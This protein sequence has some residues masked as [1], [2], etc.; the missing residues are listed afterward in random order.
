MTW[1]ETIEHS[2]TFRF[3]F[4]PADETGFVLLKDVAN[5]PGIGTYSTSILFPDVEATNGT[6]Q[7][8]QIIHSGPVPQ[9][10]P[11]GTVH[12]SCADVNLVT[13][14]LSVADLD[15]VEGQSDVVH[16]VTIESSVA[17]TSQE[18]SVDYSGV[19]GTATEGSDF[20][21]TAATATMGAGE[22]TVQVE[23]DILGDKLDEDNE[24]FTFELGDSVDAS[25]PDS[26]A[27]ILIR[28]NDHR[29]TISLALSKH[30]IVSGK[31][32]VPDGPMKCARNVQVKIQRKTAS[33]WSTLTT[34]ST[35]LSGAYRKQIA[36]RPGTYRGVV[37]QITRSFGGAPHLC[38]ARTSASAGHR[39][40]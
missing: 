32:S 37:S 13:P 28:D 31:V 5:A 9:D 22:T 8:Q 15:F 25:I 7:M 6:L 11:A 17:L 14:E 16:Q 36:D 30:L 4:S 18:V 29:R 2:G 34:D 19:P 23:V 26:D 3:Q 12:Y 38:L 35:D 20:D 1:E 39:H 21:V 33:G 24:F 10:P 27:S 40:T